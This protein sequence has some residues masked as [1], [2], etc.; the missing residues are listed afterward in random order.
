MVPRPCPAPRPVRAAARSL[1]LAALL[2]GLVACGSGGPTEP[3][4]D[5]ESTSSATGLQTDVTRTMWLDVHEMLTSSMELSL[6]R[7]ELPRAKALAVQAL[8]TAGDSQSLRAAAQLA[9]ALAEEARRDPRAALAHV[10][11][12][13]D[14]LPVNQT[15]SDAIVGAVLTAADLGAQASTDARAALEAWQLRLQAARA[16]VPLERVHLAEERLGAPPQVQARVEAWPDD[17]IGEIED[18][19]LA[20]Y[21]HLIE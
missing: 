12:A 1:A 5:D 17:A 4:P 2:T 19:S 11:A 20:V 15:S 13:V 16:T 21:P 18:P 14:L 3:A 8:A 10:R 7:R 9:C 6:A